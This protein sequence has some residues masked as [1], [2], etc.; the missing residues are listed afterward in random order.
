MRMQCS[1]FKNVLYVCKCSASLL[2]IFM[3][4]ITL[5]VRKESCSPVT[6]AAGTMTNNTQPQ[7]TPLYSRGGWEA[8]WCGWS[9]PPRSPHRPHAPCSE[10]DRQ[11]SSSS[12]DIAGTASR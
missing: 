8:A 3:L 2:D 9:P 6:T 10:A 4:Y 1:A 7:L 11:S 5:R 12:Q